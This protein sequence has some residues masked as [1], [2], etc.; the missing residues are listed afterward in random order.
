[1]HKVQF[2][3]RFADKWLDYAPITFNATTP[4]FKDRKAA[5]SYMLQVMRDHPGDQFRVREL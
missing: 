5:E 4:R 2:F 1:M 3:S